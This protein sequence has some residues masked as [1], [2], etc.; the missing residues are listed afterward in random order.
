VQDF[1]FP[2]SDYCIAALGSDLKQCAAVAH[3]GRIH[4]SHSVSDMTDAADYVKAD[5]YVRQLLASIGQQPDVIGCDMHPDAMV[6]HLA[7]ELAGEF[8]ASV[9][10]I[11]HH[12]AHIA[13]VLAEHGISDAVI[14]LA[15]DG[16][17]YGTDGISW[18][19]EYLRVS[20]QGCERLG[21]LKP[22][23]LPGGDQAARQPWRM[24]VAALAVAD[25]Q[26]EQV[27][28]QLFDHSL[29]V[30]AVLKLCRS[31]R[32][33]RSS[34]AGRY[35][36]AASAIITGITVNTVEA[37]AAI[38]LEQLAAGS[39][40]ADCFRYQLEAADGLLQLNLDDAFIELAGRKLAGKPAVMLAKRFHNTL[41]AGLSD[42]ATELAGHADIAGVAF[43]GGCSFNRL[44]MSGLQKRL[45]GFE[46]YH[47]EQLMP[48]DGNISTGQAWVALQLMQLF[49]GRSLQAVAADR[50]AGINLRPVEA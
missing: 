10:P 43:S 46:L 13:S 35:F 9:L 38:T 11:Q 8:G 42:L 14:G 20:D 28:A 47:N 41:I 6:G 4:I 39:D 49:D 30:A 1:A 40:D 26:P 31:E 32:T 18:G 15:L 24:A 36:D 5:R 12:H 33:A 37:E 21:C 22:L 25:V 16:F 23:P 29:P 45:S 3:G 50:V 7:A 17:G 19:G 34:S 44:L 48:G 2:V 27:I